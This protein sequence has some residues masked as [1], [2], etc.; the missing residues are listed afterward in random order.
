MSL[1]WR[2]EELGGSREAT[3]ANKAG[4]TSPRTQ[5]K[6]GRR[7]RRSLALHHGTKLWIPITA[8]FWKMRVTNMK[9]K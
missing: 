4:L 7:Q 3:R 8:T 2:W 9:R 1:T 5:A 6:K